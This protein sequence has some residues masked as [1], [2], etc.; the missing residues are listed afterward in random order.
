MVYYV[1]AELYCGQM[2][3]T[4]ASSMQE[5]VN[6]TV[7]VADC[8]PYVD[9]GN[10]VGGERARESEWER[11]SERERE[12]E[13]LTGC[14]CVCEK[15]HLCVCVCVCVWRPLPSVGFNLV[16]ICPE[17]NLDQF[18]RDVS[19][20][21][22]IILIHVPVHVWD[23]IVYENSACSESWR[24]LSGQLLLC[25]PLAIVALSRLLFEF[26]QHN[27]LERGSG[28]ASKYMLPPFTRSL[29]AFWSIFFLLFVPISA[30]TQCRPFLL[31]QPSLSVSSSSSL[32]S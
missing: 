22:I 4:D 24:H 1:Q 5:A 6:S 31:E 18:C 27:K 28:S 8:F 12:R 17:A 23:T 14:V 9:T 11:M 19:T 29:S 25:P 7:A 26:Y 10:A 30:Y 3:A 15:V 21:V 32:S 16:Q 20:S 2:P 13:S